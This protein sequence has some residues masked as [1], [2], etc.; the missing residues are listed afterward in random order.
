[1]TGQRADTPARADRAAREAASQDRRAACVDNDLVSQIIR[2][3]GEEAAVAFL[4]DF[5][6]AALS[7]QR[8][9]QR[10]DH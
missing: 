3:K 9:A 4:A 1:M 2:Y 6:M 8:P 10:P 7:A 5:L